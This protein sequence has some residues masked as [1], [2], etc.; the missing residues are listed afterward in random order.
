MKKHLL[1]TLVVILF[2][3][4][5][6]SQTNVSGNIT[7]NTT[8]T[9]AGSPY[10]LV[11]N[12]GVPAAYT[13]T[14]EPGVVVQREADYQIL[15]NGAIQFNGTTTDSIVFVSGAN[16]TV[17]SK[18]FIDFKKSS[19]GNSILSFISFQNGSGL[20]N[21][22][23]M[24]NPPGGSATI[25]Q[26]SGILH[27]S[28]SNL[29]NGY[30]VTND[31]YTDN[32]AVLN[33][34]SCYISAAYIQ[35]LGSNAELINISGTQVYNTVF[36]D[37]LFG[38]HFT[39]CYLNGASLPQTGRYSFLNCTVENSRL[40]GTVDLAGFGQAYFTS[41]TIINT[42]LTATQTSFYISNCNLV[43][44]DKVYNLD[45]TESNFL[46]TTDGLSL[47]GSQ[48]INNSAYQVSGINLAGTGY[49]NFTTVDTIVHNQFSQLYDAITVNYFP[50]IILDSN[51]FSTVG[52]Y[53]II[54]YTS[55][56]FSALY[57]YF[58]L[59]DGQT[60]NDVI[61][62]QN[63]DLSYG[64]VIYTPYATDSHILPLK[65]ISLTGSKEGNTIKLNW[66]TSN[67]VNVS[68]F[69]I[70]KK[71]GNDYTDIGTVASSNTSGGAVYSFTDA[72]PIAGNNFYRLK[73]VDADGRYTY[74]AI[75]S[76]TYNTIAKA[77]HV[78][79]NPASTYLVIEFNT[80]DV[81]TQ[82]QLVDARGRTVRT[83]TV[84]NGSTKATLNLAGIAK[85]TYKLVLQ[86]GTKRDSQTILIE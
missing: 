59:K 64:L 5:A 39:N 25:P 38:I 56:D 76:V 79:P 40:G 86:N 20:S 1:L 80:V 81:K 67:E 17:N 62:D 66:Q 10:T 36:R 3:S 71:T 57:D 22:L 53:D 2:I 16:L 35:E 55:K 48:L 28:H 42:S 50:N 83:I 27:L 24:G 31:Y 8:W 6:K 11:G 15:I 12:V 58:Q 43:F 7:Q 54:N 41:S 14:I 74:S 61:Y 78:Y 52:R 29:S 21:N 47:S 37:N 32:I 69:I 70:Q 60:I 46:I 9:K 82:L 26:N 72:T 34:D 45:G 19:L 75:I 63:D 68:K 44:T 33:I 13:L 23:F 85:G 18:F 77:L 84:A 65:L 73:T 4:K 30:T 51:S 49:N